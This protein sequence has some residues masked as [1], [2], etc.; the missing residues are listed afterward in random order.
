MTLM[1]GRTMRDVI[2][3]QGTWGQWQKASV[4]CAAGRAGAAGCTNARTLGDPSGLAAVGLTPCGLSPLLGCDC[5]RRRPNP[6]PRPPSPLFGAY[7][8]RRG[9]SSSGNRSA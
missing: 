2:P 1:F 7:T 9:S 8:M 6:A 4:P 3:W 5:T